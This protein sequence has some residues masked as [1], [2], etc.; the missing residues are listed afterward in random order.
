MADKLLHPNVVSIEI[1]QKW[2]EGDSWGCLI[3]IEIR[4]I[5]Q[6]K[7]RFPWQRDPQEVGELLYLLVCNDSFLD[8]QFASEFTKEELKKALIVD[9]FSLE[10]ATRYIKDIINQHGESTV[11][12]FVADMDHYFDM[13]EWRE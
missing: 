6:P 12:N 10:Y 7:K 13:V 9:N 4:D 5:L 8:S 2:L 11:D 3:T 1:D